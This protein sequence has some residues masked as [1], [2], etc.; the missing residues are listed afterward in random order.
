MYEFLFF[1]VFFLITRLPEVVFFLTT[2]VV[3]GSVRFVC[4][5]FVTLDETGGASRDSGI[6]VTKVQH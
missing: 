6:A 4:V 1:T 3:G 2:L 5:L